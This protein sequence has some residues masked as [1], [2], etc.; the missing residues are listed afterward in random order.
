[1]QIA[2][3]KLSV[4]QTNC[5]ILSNEEEAVA[6]DAGQNPA[7]MLEHLEA[8]GLTLTHILL[9]HLHA[10]HVCGVRFL[11]RHTNAETW[12][13][14]ADSYLQDSPLGRGGVQNLPPVPAFSFTPVEP[15][16]YN[17]LGQTLLILDT[18]GHTPGGLSY[19]F[20]RAGVVFVGDLLF[21]GSV[22]RTDW[23]GGDADALLDAVRQRIFILP[24]A[25]KVL[26]GHGP[27]TTVGHEKDANPFFRS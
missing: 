1:M 20:P 23:D 22:G 26:S 21:Q 12:G 11:Q 6:I 5:Y 7:P 9:T 15:G 18:P 14:L 3:F 27:A 17:V 8:N 25:T 24:D 2:T 10:D 13:S 19:Y 16:R 4:M